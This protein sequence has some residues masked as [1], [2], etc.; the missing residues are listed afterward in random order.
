[1]KQFYLIITI[2]FFAFIQINAQNEDS[3]VKS[4]EGKLNTGAAELR[5]VLHITK[6]DEGKLSSAMDSPDQNVKGIPGD[7]TTFDG[8][9][10]SINFP[11]IMGSFYGTV[12]EQFKTITGTWKQGGMSLPLVLSEKTDGETKENFF[13]IWQGKLKTGAAELRLVFRFFKDQNDTIG[14][15]LD[16]PDQG[17]GGF[18]GEKV[19]YGKDSVYA[20]FPL[21]NGVFTAKFNDDET[22]LIGEWKQAGTVFPL[23]LEQNETI[24]K[25]VR[26]QEP[27]KP[28]PYN[29]EQV[30][31]ENSEAGISLAGTFTYPKEGNNFP[32]VILI[33]GSGMQNR[34]EE[35]LGHKPFLIWADHLTRKGIA[36]LRFDDRGAGE[37]TGDFGSAT[38]KDF[39]SDVLSAVKYL[40]SRNEVNK[41]KIGLIGHSEGGIVAPAAANNSDDVAFII[42]AAGPAVPGRDILLLQSHLISEKMG[43]TKEQLEKSYEMNSK[44]YQVIIDSKD[45]VEI[46]MKLNSLYEAEVSGLSE[47]EKNKPEH[48]RASFEQMKKL[49]LSPWFRYFV[50]YDPRP[51]LENLDVP[52]LAIFGE[53]DLQVPP[54]QNEPEMKKA[55]EKSNSE[56]KVVVL[57]GLNHLFQEAETGLPTEY[58]QITETTSPKMLELMSNWIKE[59]T[60]E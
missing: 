9:N 20:S 42:L 59:I 44:I 28:Y 8:K 21:I 58:A 1:M 4:W 11:S 25:P 35:L 56:F 40:K 41:N 6:I 27:V 15:Y 57:P 51:A 38:T 16:S 23:E 37:S 43:A 54:S 12:D 52:V 60:E 32:A 24:E 22:K 55:L 33:S 29:E 18:I 31:F 48:S 34:D 30:K 50:K 7:S 14:V 46:D 2:L 49:I 5:L 39:E 13:A 47:E 10:I 17:V 36:V 45:S 53:K 19:V 3:I 26:T